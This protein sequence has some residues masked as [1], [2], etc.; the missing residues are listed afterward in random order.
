METITVERVI[1]APIEDTFEWLATTTNYTVTPYA[2]RCR[3]ATPG[4]DAPYGTGAVRVHTWLIGWF[5]ERITAYDPPHSFE[6]HVEKGI[7]PAR[8]ELGRMAFTE[9]GGGTKVVWTTRVEV[10]LPLIGAA[11]TR[12]LAR[13]VIAFVFGRILDA[14]AQELSTG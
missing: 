9:D 12:V 7:P 14:A 2:I 1:P 13:P 4:E 5:R 3:L 8:H 11:V 10:R 6:Y